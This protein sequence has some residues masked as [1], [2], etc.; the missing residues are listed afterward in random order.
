[1]TVAIDH[2]KSRQTDFRETADDYRGELFRLGRYRVAVC[3]YGIQWLFQRQRRRSAVGGA[4][5]DTLGYCASRTGLI[6]L[7]REYGAS[8]HHSLRQ[9]PEHFKRDGRQ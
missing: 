4:A 8:V 3:S 2:I 6:R 1:M 7:H 5:W 9:L